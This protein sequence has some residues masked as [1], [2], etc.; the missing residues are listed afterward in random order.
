[1]T[2]ETRAVLANCSGSF[3]LLLAFV[4][5]ILTSA[6]LL[7][8]VRG[9]W[10]ARNASP[11]QMARLQGVADRARQQTADTAYSVVDP[12]IQLA[13]TWSGIKAGVRVFLGAPP[14]STSPDDGQRDEI[15]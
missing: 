13:S 8:F 14:D 15:T 3:L 7:L 1:M 9:L 11:E 12:Q 10:L 2:P 4:L 5:L 6:L